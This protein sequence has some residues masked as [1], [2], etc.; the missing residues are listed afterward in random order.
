MFDFV[1]GVLGQFPIAKWAAIGG[2]F[3]LFFGGRDWAWLGFWLLG[4]VAAFCIFLWVMI[5]EDEERKRK[6]GW[7]DKP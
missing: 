4:A 7:R 1:W 5:E 6:K 3:L 2:L